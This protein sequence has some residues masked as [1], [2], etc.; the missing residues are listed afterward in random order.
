MDTS[1]TVRNMRR[2][3]WALMLREQSA[4]GLSVREWCRQ[5]HLS[6]KA[7]Y[8]RR[9]Q[10]QTMVLETAEKPEFAELVMP[11]PVSGMTSR[12]VSNPVYYGRGYDNLC[13]TGHSAAADRRCT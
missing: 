1:L 9:R 7:F 11:E 3:A 2:Q 8:Y 12:I 6:V 10:V 5:N 13:H 4:S